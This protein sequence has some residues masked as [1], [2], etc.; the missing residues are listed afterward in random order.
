MRYTSAPNDSSVSHSIA[1]SA[2]APNGSASEL[3]AVASGCGVGAKS[4]VYSGRKPCH[5]SCAHASA[6]WAS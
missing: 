2:W 3:T 6:H 4:A 5:A 1:V